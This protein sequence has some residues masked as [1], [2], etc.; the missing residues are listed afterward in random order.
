MNNNK[1]LN[2]CTR[3]LTGTE[4][5][6]IAFVSGPDNKIKFKNGRVVDA[7]FRDGNAYVNP[8]AVTI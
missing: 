6:A 2:A 7:V 5:K 1:R 8:K 3:P 4:R